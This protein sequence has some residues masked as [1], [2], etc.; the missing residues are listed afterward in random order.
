MGNDLKEYCLRIIYWDGV[1]ENVIDP[2]PGPGAELGIDFF[3]NVQYKMLAQVEDNNI[4]DKFWNP[5]ALEGAVPLGLADPNPGNWDYTD[6]TF[7]NVFRR[8]VQDNTIASGQIG[9]LGNGFNGANV[10]FDNFSVTP[11]S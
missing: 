9:L 3:P 5:L 7:V 6:G 1:N 8:E 4:R 11:I 2:G 10:V